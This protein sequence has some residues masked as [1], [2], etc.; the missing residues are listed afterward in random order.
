MRDKC[1]LHCVMVSS[2]GV[3]GQKGKLLEMNGGGGNEISPLC[4]VDSS[5]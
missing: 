3:V 2:L 4:I 5:I 1:N